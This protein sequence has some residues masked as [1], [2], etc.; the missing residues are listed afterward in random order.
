MWP[1]CRMTTAVPPGRKS[2]RRTANLI[3]SHT[4][5]IDVGPFPV[6]PF[7]RRQPRHRPTI[8]LE[9][10]AQVVR[11]VGKRDELIVPALEPIPCRPVD[12]LAG[13]PFFSGLWIRSERCH[14]A[15]IAQAE[16]FPPDLPARILK[17]TH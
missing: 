17:Q 5:R 6:E 10:G 12:Q 16:P 9:R 14:Y 2:T 1:R 7:E 4:R 13:L 15:T 3:G 11:G 8:L